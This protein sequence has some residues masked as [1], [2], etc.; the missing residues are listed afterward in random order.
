[1]K[2]RILAMLLVACMLLG[3]TA[4]GE[5]KTSTGEVDTSEH[6]TIT[7][8][9]TGDKPDGA[10]YDRLEEMRAKLNAILTEK[11]NADLEFY[12]LD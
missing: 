6:V 7:Y 8:M 11:C 2:K 5:K 1:M 12:R 9:F 4:C 10:A 3:M